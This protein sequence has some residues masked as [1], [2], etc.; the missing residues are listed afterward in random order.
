MTN[1]YWPVYKNL[2]DEFGKLMFSI[3]IDDN[4]MNVYS[5]KISD[6][7]LRASTEIE[8]ISKEL[9]HKNWGQKKWEIK[10]DL[11][12]LEHLEKIWILSKKVIIVSS[13]NCFQSK[14]EI[15]PFI[16]DENRTGTQRKTFGWNNSYQNLKHDRAKSLKFGSIKYLFDVMAALFILNIYYK[17][18]CY[19]LERD[20]KAS[21]F[22]ISL[23]SEIFAIKLHKLISYD[24]NG[25]YIKSKEFEECIYFTKWTEKTHKI[26]NETMIEMQKKR[27]ELFNK[28]PKF[29]KFIKENDIKQYEWNNLIRDV[30]WKEDF[31]RNIQQASAF[32]NTTQ[33][34]KQIEYEAILNKNKI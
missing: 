28:H 15:K 8:S 19:D 5:S 16:K 17:D 29:L 22:P 10:Y 25:T 30:L 18:E 32:A 3:H 20:S 24:G 14:K 2:E 21:N 13:Y 6:L 23:W 1:I 9:Y 4:Q 33:A 26:Y 31:I 12:A 34:I 27:I 7:I 11:D